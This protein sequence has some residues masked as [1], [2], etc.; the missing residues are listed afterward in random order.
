MEQNLTHEYL[1][2]SE[3]RQTVISL[4]VQRDELKQV[5]AALDS[6]I[7]SIETQLRKIE[8]S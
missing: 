1:A 4:K 5:A 7:E 3:L 2:V 8:T 6:R